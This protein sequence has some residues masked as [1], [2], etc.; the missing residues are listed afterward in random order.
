MIVAAEIVVTEKNIQTVE[1][2][3]R[4]VLNYKLKASSN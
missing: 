4:S 2:A 1:F 3:L